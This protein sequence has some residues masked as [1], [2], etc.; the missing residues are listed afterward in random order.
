MTVGQANN[1]IKT[2][3]QT[4][5]RPANV[6]RQLSTGDD[7]AQTMNNR[8]NA[9]AENVDCAKRVASLESELP[10]DRHVPVFT[11]KCFPSTV[12]K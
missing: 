10:P 5:K 6:W 2:N 8:D 12:E 9:R 11:D 7:K 4:K 3:K 1:A